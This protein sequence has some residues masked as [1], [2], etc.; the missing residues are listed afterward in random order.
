MLKQ[1]MKSAMLFFLAMGTASAADLPSRLVPPVVTLP[2]PTYSWTGL[3]F[4]GNVGGAFTD[5]DTIQSNPNDLVTASQITNGTVVTSYQLQKSG[6]AAGGQ[7]G[8]NY[9]IPSNGT[10]LLSGLD[11]IG[12]GGGI[13]PGGIVVGVEADAAYTALGRSNEYIGA[14]Q[15]TSLYHQRL[16]YIGTV[17]G[18][19]GYAFDRVLIYGTGGFAYGETQFGQSIVAGNADNLPIWSG[20]R[21]AMQTGYAVGGG[22]EY[23]IETAGLINLFHAGSVTVRGEFLHYDLG[24]R[25]VNLVGGAGRPFTFTDTYATAGNLV[26]ARSTTSSTSPLRCRSSRGI[27]RRV[28]AR[29]VAVAGPR[30]LRCQPRRLRIASR[31]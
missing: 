30:P 8:Y 11:R 17:R 20:N 16:D 9:Q 26:R 28:G 2:I 3:Y 1:S 18:R 25:S 10:S 7:I 5:R 19:L 27:R 21:S 15:V 12:L 24:T 23:A 6:V 4:G 22:V 14:F 29:S 13:A 31:S